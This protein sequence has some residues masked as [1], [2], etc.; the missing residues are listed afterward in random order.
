MDT[1]LDLPLLD[2]CLDP[3]LLDPFLVDP[4]MPTPGDHRTFWG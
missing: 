4:A 1:V 3:F 2:P